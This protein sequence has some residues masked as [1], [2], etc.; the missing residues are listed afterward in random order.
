M[1]SY[2]SLH[3]AEQKQGNQFEPTDS[4]SVRIQDV[5]LLE[6]MNDRE[7]RREKVRDICADGTTRWWW[8]SILRHPLHYVYTRQNVLV[9]LNKL[10][11]SFLPFL[12]D[13]YGIF[14]IT[15]SQ[16]MTYLAEMINW[17]LIIIIIIM[18]CRQHGY[19]WLSLATSPYRSSPLVG[20][21][22]YIP[23]P[24]RAAACMFELVILLLLGHIWGSIG[25]HHLWACPCFSSS[26]L[27]V[28]FV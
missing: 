24:H 19:P 28:W 21:Q 17:N 7:R 1:Y 26:V 18:S 2:G 6:A 11:L 14:F 9:Y 3:M 20:L 15:M 27:H 4:S 22:G 12:I 16:Q 5:A 10:I 23:Y 13:F 8:W 25:V